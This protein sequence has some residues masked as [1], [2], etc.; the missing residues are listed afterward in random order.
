MDK[1]DI[2]IAVVIP[3]WTGAAA[4]T[5]ASVEAQTWSAD[6]VEVAIG[7]SPNG[8]A[9][10]VGVAATAA[11]YLVFVDD[12]AVLATP[13]TIQNLV[14]PLYGDATI[15]ITGASKLIP[16]NSAWFQR[17]VA[18]EIPRIEHPVID[19]PLESNPDPPHYSTEITT[20]CCAMRRADFDQINGFD[21]TLVR[22]VDTE[23]FVRARRNGYR[24]LLV[25]HT[26]TWHPAPKNLW[27]LW[28]KHFLYGLGHGQEISAD[29]SRAKGLQKYPLRYLLFR[30]LILVP[31]IFIPYSYN[32]QSWRLGFKP[33]KAITSYIGAVGFV[34]G[35]YK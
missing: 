1:P 9:R 27:E 7:I 22:G 5:L 20:T 11:E 3:S 30:T 14:A 35:S 8:R 26:W 23:F 2:T 34:W 32:A 31:N 6:E 33:L 19:T 16:P 25:P 15:H 13:D 29:P 12:D 24:F 18:R 17:W 21:E 4:G 28:R 10:N